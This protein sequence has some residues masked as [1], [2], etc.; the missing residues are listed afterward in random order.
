MIAAFLE[1]ALRSLV[2][3]AVVGGGLR[4]FRVRNVLAQKWAWAAVL[5]GAFLMPVVQ[6]VAARWKSLPAATFVVPRQWLQSTTA[7][8]TT[9]SPE[10][11]Q[12][13]ASPQPA[14]AQ[15]KPSAALSLP[16]A[17]QTEFSVA[18]AE[19]PVTFAVAHAPTPQPSRG[20]GRIGFASLAIWLYFAVTG[21]LLLRLLYGLAS[22]LQLWRTAQP[23]ALDAAYRLGGGGINL[24]FSKRVSSPVTIGSGVVL[25]PDY[26]AWDPGKLRVVLAHERSHIQQGD[27]YLQVLAALYA[28]I[29]WFSPLGWWLK[30]KLY[31]LGETIGD[32][33]G[34]AEAADCCSYA[35]I[36]LE[37]A[38]A[39]RFTTMGV[40]MARQSSISR[41]IE[42]LLD[43][44]AFR[45]AFAASRRTLV[46]TVL[47]V[48]AMYAATTLVRVEAATH[49][50]QQSAGAASAAPATGQSQPE[51]TRQAPAD[52][53]QA[54]PEPA[55]S[56][57]EN[58]APSPTPKP[59]PGSPARVEV[60]PVHV[61]V[62]AIHV[63]V[64][65]QHIDVPEIHVNVPAVHVDVP[66]Q[67]IDVPAV[68]V[69][70][71][72][73]HIDVP[74]VHVNVPATHVDVPAQHIDVPAIHIDVPPAG[75]REP[76]GHAS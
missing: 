15:A 25:P 12:I 72:A 9:P 49:A 53:A 55:P 51:L 46:T 67:H 61:N 5:A 7:G 34:L 66:A 35:Q 76:D 23:A 31:D 71:P 26:V 19:Q 41:R 24:R 75:E 28:A 68:H 3:A 33:S 4:A 27:F 69:D 52:A 40:A 13:A 42:R 60:P 29:A 59:T 63:N 37:F 64:P 74:A 10:P 43:E 22:A 1:S 30:R 36:L 70:V 21:A 73:Q 17:P 2:L 45:Q 32:R 65:A 57:A 47:V 8:S 39:P 48:A 44:S 14:P 20:R 54:Q 56:P 11:N 18:A 38:A 62:P 16:Q 58:A 6:P 50:A